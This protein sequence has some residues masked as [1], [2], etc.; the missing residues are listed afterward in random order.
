MLRLRVEWV[1]PN[2]TARS[3]SH[4]AD[5]PGRGQVAVLPFGVDHPGPATEDGLAPQEGLYEGT[6]SPADLPED[7]HVGVRH[8]PLGVELEG[9]EDKGATEQVIPYHDT[10]LA[11]A[12]FSDEGIGRAQ[13][14]GGDLVGWDPGS[15]ST[16]HVGERS[17]RVLSHPIDCRPSGR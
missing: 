7:N 12:S 3:Q 10:S 13:V 15:N 11:Q 4:R 16:E 9:I 2:G 14:S 8:H 5:S 6:L 17:V 1:Q